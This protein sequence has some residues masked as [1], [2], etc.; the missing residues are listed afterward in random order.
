MPTWM[1][2]FTV[3]LLAVFALGAKGETLDRYMAIEI[4]RLEETRRLLERFAEEIWPGW[5]NY[6][7]VEFR[8]RFPN[9]ALLAVNP[10]APPAGFQAVKGHAG[11][12]GPV[13]I[14]RSRQEPGAIRGTLLGG[15]G[16]GLQVRIHL[17]EVPG[18]RRGVGDEQILLYVHEMFH[19]FQSKVMSVDSDE[20]LLDY[21]VGAEYAALSEVEGIAME[22][23]LQ[24]PDAARARECLLDYNLARQYKRGF[25]PAAM[26]AA[27]ESIAVSEGTASYAAQRMAM[28]ILRGRYRPR[29]SRRLD[30]SF[31]GF[32]GLKEYLEAE[33]TAGPREERGDTFDTIGKYYSFGAHL[34]FLLDRFLPGWKKDFFSRGKSL[35]ALV[36]GC[37]QSPAGLGPA[38]FALRF[39]PRY[40]WK[41]ILARHAAA[42]AE[43]DAAVALLARR[44]GRAYVVDLTAIRE[45][46][47]PRPSGRQFRL[48]GTKIIY[49][50]GIQ[51]L[52]VGAVELSASAAP[53]Q[54]TDLFTLEWTAA[55]AAGEDTDPEVAWAGKEGEALRGLVYR[56]A[57][58]T[59]K[60]P[61]ARV[62][63]E[64]MVTRIEVLARRGP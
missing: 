3:L 33:M 59:L 50:D 17:R 24:E 44:R 34:C 57:G 19:G 26:A 20:A 58:F 29:L 55:A 10:P 4:G 28:L 45:F 32:R 51:A 61:L 41:R 11:H 5:D 63:A 40:G 48:P 49:P 22:R 43:R 15:G 2:L 56:T 8:F 36:A 47:R 16:G 1:R 25:I 60:A 14:D 9:Q 21:L 23:A 35:D 46:A 31:D 62:R 39:E 37:L 7:R 6:G 64:G 18:I 38:D 13:Y 42:V 54:G 12:C 53:W 30:P 27:E 52:I